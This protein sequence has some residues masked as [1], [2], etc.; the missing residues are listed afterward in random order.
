LKHEQKQNDYAAEHERR[1]DIR[2]YVTKTIHAQFA[3]K[4]NIELNND[5]N[6]QLY[7]K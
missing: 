2:S 4:R 6:E 5:L 1:E 3:Q 7:E